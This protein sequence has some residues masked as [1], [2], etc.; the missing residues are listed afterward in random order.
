M[1][2]LLFGK[3]PASY[4]KVYRQWFIE[5]HK[6]DVKNDSIPFTRSAASN[7]LYDPFSIDFENP[8]DRVKINDLIDGDVSHKLKQIDEETSEDVRDGKFNFENF[9][10]CI[11]DLSYSS[12]FSA[13]TSKK[14]DFQSI[15][16]NEEVEEDTAPR[17]SG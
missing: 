11:N 8:F 9:M 14:F 4:Y 6:H 17:F 2:C 10:K 13:R 16:G 1:F 15:V 3:Q 5:H 12:M 7:F